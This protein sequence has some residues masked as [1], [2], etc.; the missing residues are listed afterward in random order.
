M[1]IFVQ[2]LF[3]ATAIF[4]KKSYEILYKSYERSSNF[5][6]I[7][8]CCPHSIFSRGNDALERAHA[9]MQ[10]LQQEQTVTAVL[11]VLRSVRSCHGLIVFVLNERLIVICS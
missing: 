7:M 10:R 4:D 9:E 3:L 8:K 6:E 5:I 2:G 1:S 11:N